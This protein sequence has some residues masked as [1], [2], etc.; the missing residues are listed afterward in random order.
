MTI[1]WVFFPRICEATNT[2]GM[3]M[4]RK[5]VSISITRAL[6]DQTSRR[7]KSG[8]SSRRLSS[9]QSRMSE[10]GCGLEFHFTTSANI[11]VIFAAQKRILQD[12]AHPGKRYPSNESGFKRAVGSSLVAM[13]SMSRG[14]APHQTD[15]DLILYTSRWL[16]W[17]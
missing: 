12:V 17:Y 9:L 11:L 16:G 13:K 10:I 4:S 14:A 15:D 1:R 6:S 8:C 7:W 5:I 2:L 3:G